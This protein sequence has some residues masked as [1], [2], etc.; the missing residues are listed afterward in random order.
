[1]R[2]AKAICGA[3]LLAGACAWAG[4]LFQHATVLQ[5]DTTTCLTGHRSVLATL[6][7][8]EDSPKREDCAEYIL[9]S[10]TT[11]FRVQASRSQPLLLPGEDISF[12]PGKGSLRIRRDDES[13]EFDVSVICMRL[14][15]NRQGGCAL[16][17]EAPKV[18]STRSQ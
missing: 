10:P 8:A 3:L 15:S 14:R 16:A 7:G 18:A 9:V 11:L 1:M 12:R 5:M 13:G 17:D 2:V 4:G 6:S